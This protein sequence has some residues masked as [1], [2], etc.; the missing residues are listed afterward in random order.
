[1]AFW[2][3]SPGPSWWDCIESLNP[4]TQSSYGISNTNLSMVPSRLTLPKGLHSLVLQSKHAEML[5]QFLKHHFTIYPRC[6][7]TLSKERIQQGFDYEEWIAVGIFT[8]DKKLVGCCFSK[9]LGRMKFPH[10]TLDQGGIVDYFCVH[11]DYRKQGIASFLLEEL[12]C[13]T[14]K[15]QRLVHIFIKE[16]F[17]LLQ[18]PPL[19]VS[20]Y[21]ARRREIPGE[22]KNY[23]GSQGIALHSYIQMFSH[24]D[25]LPLT[26]FVANFPYQLNGDSEL[27]GFNYKGNDVFLCMTDLHHCSV[28]EGFKLGELTW[29]LPKTM[30]VPLSVQ[31][32][33]VEACIDC[34]KF[35]IVLMDAHIPHHK[36]K[37]WK[38]DA[39]Y[40]WYVFNY[41][42]GSFFTNKPFWIF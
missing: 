17:P 35:D 34:S 39:T 22:E 16:G 13:L 9:P 41:N 11:K 33:A 23:L 24:A 38:K 19:Y 10:E 20:E 21:I 7:I 42:P 26:K 40:S 6:R 31:K 32:L 27:F 3:Q 1:M 25:F 36:K 5:H 15:K 12:K 29:M 18:L 2:N 8:K 37:P 28:P 14:A 4:C 30:E